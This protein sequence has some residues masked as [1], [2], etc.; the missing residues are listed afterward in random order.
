MILLYLLFVDFTVHVYKFN[1]L[2]LPLVI[3]TTKNALGKVL[4]PRNGSTSQLYTQ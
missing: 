1:P 3:T 4:G 2:Y